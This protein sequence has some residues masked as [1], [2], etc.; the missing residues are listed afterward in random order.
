M[1]ATFAHIVNPVAVTP[2]SDLHAAQPITFS[3]MRR[4][5]EE[6]DRCGI[7]V[8]Q[9]VT[10]FAKDRA[11][12]PEGFRVAPKLDRSIKTVA[13]F[14]TGREL[15]L[16]ADILDRLYRSSDADY[17]IYTNVD[18]AL[19][20]DF[21]L[22]VNE[23][24][25]QG[26]DT[27]VINRRTIPDRYTDPADLP[28]M[29]AEPGEQHPGHDCFVFPRILYVMFDVGRV[30][31]GVPPVG[32][33]LIWNLVLFGKR[34]HEFKD[35]HLTF[36]VGNDKVWKQRENERDADFNKTEAHAVLERLQ[37]RSGK[38]YKD[39]PIAPYLSPFGDPAE[40]A[41]SSTERALSI[42]KRFWRFLQGGEGN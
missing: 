27:L 28:L 38:F 7:G 17:L 24:I 1:S 37:A 3:S 18:I 35:L 34:F 40:R 6:A 26:F 12:F 20:P 21:Y 42:Y 11:I 22:R 8:Q 31:I 13:G 10:G 23:L 29:Y 41:G 39:D 19:M 4:A 15:P 25:E 9:I 16:L 32:R 30:C 33:V 5:R 36:H 2:Q 14:D